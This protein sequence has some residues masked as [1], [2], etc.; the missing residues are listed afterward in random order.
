ML[1]SDANC[2]D[3]MARFYSNSDMTKAEYTADDLYNNGIKND[4]TSSI[5][6]PYGYTAELWHDNFWT[7][8]MVKIIGTPFSDSNLTLTC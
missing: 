7:G 6:V 4:W 3:N 2:Q 8:N 5:I 1:F